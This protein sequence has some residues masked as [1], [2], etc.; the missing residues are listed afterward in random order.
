MPLYAAAF[1]LP[2]SVAIPYLLEDVYIRGGFR[3]VKTIDLRNAIK[4]ASRKQ[5]MM[6]YVE[7]DK[8]IYTIVGSIGGVQA[9]SKWNASTYVELESDGVVSVEDTDEGGKKLVADPKRVVPV[10]TEEEAN[11]VLLSSITGPVWAR[12]VFVPD[13]TGA[14]TGNAVVLN[15]EGVAVWA[16]VD[17][18]PSVAEAVEGDTLLLDADKKPIWGK[19]EALPSRDGTESGMV[20]GLDETLTPVWTFNSGLPDS[21][22]VAAG[23]VVTLGDDQKARW[24]KGSEVQPV[25]EVLEVPFTTIVVEKFG[26]QVITLEGSTVALIHVELSDPDL[27]LEIHQTPEYEDTNPYSFRSSLVSL[28][29]D[30]KTVMEDGTV[31]PSRRY[32][33]F[34]CLDNSVKELYAR[35]HNE[36]GAS[37]DAVLKLTYVV[38]E[39]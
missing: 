21:A 8:T 36:S 26:D 28:V 6:V 10:A 4:P 17:G 22:G 24:A 1:F 14:S 33:I 23:S 25:R 5:G 20:L 11:C 16:K 2:T 27:M 18:L 9:W 15:E 34:S 3:S 19:V 30:G 29:D 39:R 37:V 7:E 31:L 12:K 32:A 13:S 38:L 35:I